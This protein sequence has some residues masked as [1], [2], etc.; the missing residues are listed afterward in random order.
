M[1][2]SVLFILGLFAMMLFCNTIDVSNTIVCSD[3]KCYGE[4]TGAE[5]VNGSDIAHQ[6]SNKMSS[7]VGKKLKELFKKGMYSKVNFDDI[8][9]TTEGMGSGN[10]TYY[11]QI[12]F[13]RVNTKCEAYTSFDH[14]GGW[15]HIPALKA[16]K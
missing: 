8:I 5:F 14:V 2:K 3:K 13:K 9:M 6:F 15:N 10:V 11:L 7:R 1:K 12:P 4:Y 16:R